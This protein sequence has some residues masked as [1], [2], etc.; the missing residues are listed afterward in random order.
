MSWYVRCT[1]ASAAAPRRPSS[2]AACRPA[3][4]ANARAVPGGRLPCARE[5]RLRERG[6]VEQGPRP[7]RAHRLRPATRTRPA[8][9][10]PRR[11]CMSCRRRC[12]RRRAVLAANLETAVNGLWDA[13]AVSPA[14]A[15]PSSARGSSGAW[16]PGWPRAHLAAASNWW[17]S[18][19]RVPLSRPRSGFRS[20]NPPTPSRDVD[21]VVHA[22]GAPAGLGQALD[23]AGF[24]ATGVEMSWFGDQIVPLPLGGAFHAKRLTIRSSQVGHVARPQ[25]GR[26]DTRRR[27]G[28][29]LSLLTRCSDV[30]VSGESAF[31]S[32]RK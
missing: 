7:S 6:L 31:A 18:T 23:L 16:W 26:W 30:L 2:S 3:S 1:A 28:L 14:T 8:T 25:R 20:P 17:I 15:S 19:P 12:H 32:C 4:G 27:M 24:E 13:Q 29:A 11:R 22:S 9:S 10:C 21:L 5:V